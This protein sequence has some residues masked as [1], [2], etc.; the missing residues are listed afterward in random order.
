MY[1]FDPRATMSGS[2]YSKLEGC[3]NPLALNFGAQFGSLSLVAAGL[4]RK[5]FRFIHV[6]SA[7]GRRRRQ[8]HR[9]PPPPPLP[10]GRS[11][12]RKPAVVAT[13]LAGGDVS[14]YD[15]ETLAS[16][17][18]FFASKAGVD[19]SAV[20]ITVT[21]ASVLLEIIIVFLDL[22]SADAAS[23]QIANALG[24]SAAS[25]S[26]ALGIVV[27]SEPFTS[28]KEILVEGVAVPETVPLL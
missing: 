4:T 19:K 16:L 6:R 24:N 5:R 23:Q 8:R 17:T 1:N 13:M 18:S 26:A 11:D 14:D 7:N 25:A 20:T 10:P 9:L 28:A 15:E 3:L 2:C 21:P 22:E 12:T 27:Q